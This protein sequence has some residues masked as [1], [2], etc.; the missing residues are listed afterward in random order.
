MNTLDLTV[1]P[2][3][4]AQVPSSTSSTLVLRS[5]GETAPFYR[6][7]NHAYASTAKPPI[8]ILYSWALS[9]SIAAIALLLAMFQYVSHVQFVHPVLLLAVVIGVGGIALSNYTRLRSL[10][11]R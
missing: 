4:A 8:A 5:A 2:F 1:K 10:W 3:H 11:Q 7:M 6:S 9:S